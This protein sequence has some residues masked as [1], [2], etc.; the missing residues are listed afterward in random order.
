MLKIDEPAFPPF[1]SK[2]LLSAWTV[3]HENVKN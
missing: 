1:V 3:T 2:C